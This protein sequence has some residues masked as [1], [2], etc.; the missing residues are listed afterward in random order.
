MIKK[1]AVLAVVA[2]AG[3]VAY[4]RFSSAQAERDLWNE[5]TAAPDL[6]Q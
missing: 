6:S 1:L 4:N 5:A 2:V 3:Y